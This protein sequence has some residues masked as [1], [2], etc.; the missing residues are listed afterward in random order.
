[1]VYGHLRERG[2]LEMNIIHDIIGIIVKY[3]RF[4]P[5]DAFGQHTEHDND[6]EVV[7]G[8]ASKLRS[9]WMSIFGKYAFKSTDQL[10]LSWT[11]KIKTMRCRNTEFIAIGITSNGA[12]S[13]CFHWDRDSDN[14]GYLSNGKRGSKYVY[15]PYG[16]PFEVG[17]VIKMTL[18]L[19]GKKLTYYQDDACLGNAYHDIKIDD[20]ISYRMAVLLLA[21]QDEITISDFKMEFR[22]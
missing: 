7:E 10:V 4:V 3:T 12:R 15:S 18:D 16:K 13:G 2:I 8:T 9:S 5:V 17:S 20:S 19:V 21:N 11:F 1:M 22:D 6:Y 14:Y